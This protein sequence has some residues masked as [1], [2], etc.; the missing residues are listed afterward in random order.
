MISF[1]RTFGTYNCRENQQKVADWAQEMVLKCDHS[2]RSIDRT[3]GQYYSKTRS[4]QCTTVAPT[5]SDDCPSG[6][7]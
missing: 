7:H 5:L 2:K 1:C 4:S 6:R 3:I